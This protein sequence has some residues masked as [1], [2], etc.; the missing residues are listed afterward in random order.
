[1]TQK[2]TICN[3]R[4]IVPIKHTSGKRNKY[5]Y[6]KHS[7]FTTELFL[8]VDD[9]PKLSS[10]E[11]NF[12]DFLGLNGTNNFWRLT[13]FSHYC[14]LIILEHVPSCFTLLT[15]M[16]TADMFDVFPV[17]KSYLNFTLNRG[18]TTSQVKSFH[19]KKKV[20]SIENAIL[21]TV[22]SRHRHQGQH[23]LPKVLTSN[24]Y[25]IILI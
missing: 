22:G 18:I 14:I 10:W 12:T 20:C 24:S 6:K 25:I 21:I 5:L 16:L 8:Y 23:I 7:V 9:A 13:N 11:R 4:M 15:S 1:M 19:K 3:S 2:T 17:L